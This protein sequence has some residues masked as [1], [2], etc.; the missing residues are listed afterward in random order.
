MTQVMAVEVDGS[1]TSLTLL[2]PKYVGDDPV[3]TVDELQ[4]QVETLKGK[5]KDVV[6][7]EPKHVSEAVASAVSNLAGTLKGVV[8]F[9]HEDAPCPVGYNDLGVLLI[10]RFQPSFDTSS[11]VS[12]GGKAGSGDYNG[13]PNIRLDHVKLC[14]R[15]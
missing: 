5:L 7:S 10:P 12:P 4:S 3:D 14:T 1:G 8:A 2:W 13:N 6:D 15:P 11:F 9:A